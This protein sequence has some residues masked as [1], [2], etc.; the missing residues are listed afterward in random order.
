MHRTNGLLTPRRNWLQRPPKRA[1]ETRKFEKGST[2]LH[3]DNAMRHGHTSRGLRTF[4][5]LVSV[6]LGFVGACSESISAPM[7]Q[8]SFKHPAQYTE[9]IGVT[10]FVYDPSAV[11]V[12]RLDNHVLVVPAGGVCD[13]AT[14]SY[15][16]EFWDSDCEPLTHPLTITATTLSDDAGHPYIDFE[17]ALRFVPTMESDLYLYDG[18]RDTANVLAIDYCNADAVCV[19]ESLTDS[20][21]VTQ[22]IGT[23][24]FLVR[25]VKHFSGY[26]VGVGDYCPGTIIQDPLGGLLCDDGSGPRSGY[27]LASGL[28]KN[29]GATTGVRRK[30]VKQ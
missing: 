28:E 30:K 20:S 7:R 23:S 15:G 14:S 22:R 18:Q 12:Q 13:P 8:V 25:R 16:P 9:V 19:D 29:A 2:T 24:R 6:G 27:M 1:E 5:I 4:A 11:L 21:L 26:S 3:K 17:P 10:E